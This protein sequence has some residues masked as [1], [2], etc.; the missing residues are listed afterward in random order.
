MHTIQIPDW[1]TIENY[2]TMTAEKKG[3]ARAVRV[4]GGRS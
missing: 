1:T 4:D 2:R 3:Q